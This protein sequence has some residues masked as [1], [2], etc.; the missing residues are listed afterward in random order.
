MKRKNQP[1]GLA[2]TDILQES[3]EHLKE[4]KKEQDVKGSAL[5]QQE[6]AAGNAASSEQSMSFMQAQWL[7]L[8]GKAPNSTYPYELSAAVCGAP[9]SYRA[10]W[11]PGATYTGKSWCIGVNGDWTKA[12]IKSTSDSMTLEQGQWLQLLGKSP[13]STYPYELSNKVCAAAF[14]YYAGWHQN[15][16]YT[17][18]R[19]CVGVDGHWG[20][21]V[22]ESTSES[23]TLKQAQWLQALGK[24]LSSTYPYQLSTTVCSANSFKYYADWHQNSKYVGKSWCTGIDGS[25]SNAV[26]ESTS[27]SMNLEQAQ[28]VQALGK[29]PSSTYPYELSSKVCGAAFPYRASWHQGAK[30]T[31]MSWCT[32]VDG[33]WSEAVIQ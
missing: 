13:F 28:W 9:F 27:E 12:V 21:A 3:K 33:H 30:Y 22:I 25:W 5:L 31:G 11:H 32:G 1:Q 6:G 23:M 29:S 8:L 24:T 17:G 18:K 7:S 16:K 2:E 26:I 14:G 20:D 4:D 19:W 15:S 10:S